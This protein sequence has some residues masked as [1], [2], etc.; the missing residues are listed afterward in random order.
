MAL[1]RRKAL[2][3]MSTPEQLDR[4][5]V[6]TP[7]RLWLAVG[8]GIALAVA[9]C[10]WGIFGSVYDTVSSF[11]LYYSSG[12]L[13]P[14]SS[15]TEGT[16]LSCEVMEGDEITEGEL[17][18]RILGTDG[19]ETEVTSPQSG[20][21]ESIGV[22]K[23]SYVTAGTV[24]LRY[25]EQNADGKAYVY[26][27]VPAEDARRIETGMKVQF[28][29]IYLNT[30]ETGHLTGQVTRVSSSVVSGDDLVSRVGNDD[31]I[32]RILERGPFIA[33]ICSL[34]EDPSSSNGCL[35]SSPAGKKAKLY[36]ESRM[37]AEFIISRSSPLT[38]LFGGGE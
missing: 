37:T 17:L 10:L 32:D 5:V 2:E 38:L 22:G 33:V 4:A 13:L 19:R 11:S 15:V 3:R 26:C 9:L 35:W 34:D 20:T 7:P 24:L 12:S 36:N 27:L 1:Y 31:L 25:W 30:Q 29:P 23:G 18:F 6:L 28:Y 14:V 8:A 21:V 16:V